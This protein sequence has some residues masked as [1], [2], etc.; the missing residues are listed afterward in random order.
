MPNI[1]NPQAVKFCDEKIRPMADLYAQAYYAFKAL[2]DGWDAQGIATLIPN[3]SDVIADGSVTQG[4]G[5]ATITGVM[6]NGLIANC[7]AFIT[8]LEATSK[9]KLLGLLKIAV[10][11]TR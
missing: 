4:D 7:K 1:T 9:T 10:N 8:D 3:T 6:V 11:P 5:R 2:A